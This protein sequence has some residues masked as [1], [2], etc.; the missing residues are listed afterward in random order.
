LAASTAFGLAALFGF[1]LAG[2][3]L[4]R[5][6]GDP[7]R[8]QVGDRLQTTLADQSAHDVSRHL[9]P[10]G[11]LGERVGATLA[12][13]GVYAEIPA[14]PPSGLGP[15]IRIRWQISAIPVRDLVTWWQIPAS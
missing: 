8:R 5:G 4:E 14:G 2:E 1:P 10:L 13:D 6:G 15:P 12:G 7:D 9:K 3:L 11:G